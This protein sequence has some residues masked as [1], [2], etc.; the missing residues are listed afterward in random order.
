MKKLFL[1]S[2][3]FLIISFISFVLGQDTTAWS[4]EDCIN[5]AYQNNIQIKRQQLQA[6]IAGNDFLQSKIQI[7]P[8]LNA[9]YSRQ[10]GDGHQVDPFINDFISTSTLSDY[11]GLSTNLN[12]F[13]GLQTYN[14]IQMNKYSMLS[15]LQ[16]VE[17]QKVDIS[18]QIATSY[19]QILFSQEILQVAKSQLDVTKLT[20]ERTKQLVEVGNAAKGDLLE[21][22]SQMAEEKLNVTNAENQL[23]LAYLSLGQLLDIDTIENFKIIIP[24]T[25]KVDDNIALRSVYDIYNLSVDFMPHIKS[26]EYQVMSYQKYLAIQK[27]RRSPQ[28]GLSGSWSTGY[29]KANIDS[30]T[31]DVFPYDEQ[32]QKMGARTVSLGI[33]IPIFNRWTVNNSISNAKLSLEDS[34]YNLDQTKQQL[35]KEIQQAHSDALSAY[36]KYNSA[37]EA[38]NSYTESFQYT[39]Q[40][41]NVGIINS[42]DYNISKNNLIKAQ[43][44]LVRA[45]YEC[46]FKLKILDFYTG[47]A[48]TL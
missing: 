46:I 2:V 9:N 27:G 17:R 23:T 14:A 13:N 15:K 11:Y 5:Y 3:I 30:L 38:V 1:L 40:K 35:F 48:I 21:I 8:D 20:L 43:A 47:K 29:S 31:N 7:L 44:E 10:Y 39:E 41:F 16:D 32:L 25:L 45:K 4:L 28:I 37:M 24:D 22:Q 18:L 26:A 12:L 19:L 6:E 36:D 34:Q 33:V 42:V